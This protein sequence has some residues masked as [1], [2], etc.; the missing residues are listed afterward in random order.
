MFN[1]PNSAFYGNSAAGVNLSGANYP[2]DFF[3]STKAS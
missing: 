1:N 3:K 2:E